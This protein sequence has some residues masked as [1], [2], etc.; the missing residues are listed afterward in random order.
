MPNQY[1]LIKQQWDFLAHLFD[2]CPLAQGKVSSKA[3][4]RGSQFSSDGYLSY[5]PMIV[6][7]G[8]KSWI[9]R[10]LWNT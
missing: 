9:E 10:F 8:V 3:G 7:P 2:S 6:F 4:H 1:E 5:M